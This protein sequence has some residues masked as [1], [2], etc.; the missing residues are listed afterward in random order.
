MRQQSPL[1]WKQKSSTMYTEHISCS[2]CI[3]KSQTLLQ[4]FQK[5]LSIPASLLHLTFLLP[6]VLCF[7]KTQKHSGFL[8]TNWHLN[9]NWYPN[10]QDSTL[11]Y[12]LHLSNIL[13]WMFPGYATLT[14]S[15]L[16][17]ALAGRQVGEKARPSS[18]RDLTDLGRYLDCSPK[19]KWY[20][21]YSGKNLVFGLKG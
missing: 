1:L 11:L 21:T 8:N 12:L 13:S 5:L 19:A 9:L 14:F 17:L 3:P 7:K 16:Q 2:R 4:C 15:G 18:L 6:S 20:N 10:Q